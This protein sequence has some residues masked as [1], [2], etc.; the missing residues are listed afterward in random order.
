LLQHVLNVAEEMNNENEI[1]IGFVEVA[2]FV[3]KPT[4]E[5]EY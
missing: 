3:T 5:P 4:L 2:M 1:M